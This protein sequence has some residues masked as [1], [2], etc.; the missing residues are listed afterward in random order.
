MSNWLDPDCARA[1]IATARP[2]TGT[3]SAVD[4]APDAVDPAAADDVVAANAVKPRFGTPATSA[5]AAPTPLC[6]FA[7]AAVSD[8]DM[9][10]PSVAR[11]LA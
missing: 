6:V 8:A 1:A 5:F 4:A 7:V 9:A 3:G 10:E 2:A 11:T